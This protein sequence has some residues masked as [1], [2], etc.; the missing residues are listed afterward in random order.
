MA[1]GL[2]Y[3]TGPGKR[4]FDIAGSLALGSVA[5]LPTMATAWWLKGEVGADWSNIF[6]RQKRV[7]LGGELFDMLKIRTLHIGLTEGQ[8]VQTNGTYDL[9]AGPRG[10][11]AR[12]IGVDETPQF[13]N[14]LKG[15]M[16]L[17]GLRAFLEKD[18]ALFE[19]AAPKLYARW[20][21]LYNVVRPAM[22]G[23]SQIARRKWD[24]LVPEA[25]IETMETDLEYASDATWALDAT[26]LATTPL[27]VLR[28]TSQAGQPPE[29]AS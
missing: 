10:L 22:T 13:F 21:P 3:L 8:P 1:K 20:R 17:V 29:S 12:K 15:E 23:L 24:G 2:E 19:A 18:F 26:I 25:C 7:G 16:S 28:A 5:L 27:E 9:R 11:Q 14:V 6:M 4:A